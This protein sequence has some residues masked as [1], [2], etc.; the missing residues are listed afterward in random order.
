MAGGTRPKQKQEIDTRV[1]ILEAAAA[2]LI[3]RGGAEVSMAEIAQEA[4]VSRQAVYL[5]FSDRGELFV[6]LVQYVDEKRGLLAEVERIR[7][8]STGIAALRAIVNLQA[9]TNPE[10]WP[11]AR[12][13]EAVRRTDE[14][15]ERAWQD[16]QQH[17]YA[18][19]KAIVKRLQSEGELREELPP[20]V[21]ADLLWSL[22]SLRMWEDLVQV[23]KWKAADYEKRISAMLLSVLTKEEPGSPL[24]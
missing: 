7:N 10:I 5:H 22:I 13:A 1:R 14:A 15:M 6:A 19:C 24:E 17:R 12:A 11:L 23:R 4:G 16:R 20:H 18:G 3:R 21:A 8:A 9:R 2:L